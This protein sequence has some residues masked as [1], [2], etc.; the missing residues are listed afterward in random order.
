MTNLSQSLLS[1]VYIPKICNHSSIVPEVFLSFVYVPKVCYH[2]SMYP[3][4][5]IIQIETLFMLKS[6]KYIW[7][8]WKQVIIPFIWKMENGF[9]LFIQI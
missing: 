8:I 7:I 4:F 9:E 6:L 1:V 3:K 5:V 2:S